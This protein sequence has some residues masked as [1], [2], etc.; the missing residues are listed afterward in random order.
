MGNALEQLQ[1]NESVFSLNLT[2]LRAF[3]SIH[4]FSVRN[5]YDSA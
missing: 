1:Q 4:Q 3:A 5:A 2:V